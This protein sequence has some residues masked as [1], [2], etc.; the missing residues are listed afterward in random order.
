[1]EVWVSENS[2]I[3]PYHFLPAKTSIWYF[4]DRPKLVKN[5]VHVDIEDLRDI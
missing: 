5:V 2:S 1:M 3:I 4:L